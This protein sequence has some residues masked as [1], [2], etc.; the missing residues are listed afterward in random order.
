MM[1]A[2]DGPEQCVFNMQEQSFRKYRLVSC[3][4]R[5]LRLAA[6]GR[7]LYPMY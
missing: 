6:P 3:A 7:E 5:C 2:R 1:T 4:L